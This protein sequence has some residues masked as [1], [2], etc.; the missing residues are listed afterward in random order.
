MNIKTNGSSLIS[1]IILS[2]I[3]LIILVSSLGLTDIVSNTTSAAQLSTDALFAA[4][5]TADD[6][7]IKLARNP[8]PTT[9]VAPGASITYANAVGY[10]YLTPPAPPLPGMVVAKGVS[11]K[12][13]RTI[14]VIYQ[15]R[16]D[17]RLTVLNR[18]E[19]SNTL[20]VLATP[21][22][23]STPA[24]IGAYIANAANVYL[25][26]NVNFFRPVGTPRVDANSFLSYGDGVVSPVLTLTPGVSDTNYVSG[27]VRK[28]GSGAFTFPVGDGGNYKPVVITTPLPAGNSYY[29]DV[30]YFRANPSIAVVSDLAGGF[31]APRPTGAPF[32]TSSLDTSN[33]LTA[34]TAVSPVEYWD[35]N[36]TNAINFTIAWTATSDVAT[37]TGSAL[38]KLTIVGWNGAKW[39]AVP[40]TVVS[41][42]TL[43]SGTIVTTNIPVP[44]TYM[45][46]TLGKLP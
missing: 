6:L 16:N 26:G 40:S 14:N 31:L 46:Y 36:G 11:G 2:S 7:L 5:S 20:D 28:Y 12:Y 1:V 45:V 30:A 42:S 37:L 22:P 41:G 29:M 35:I 33:P 32:S 18:Q 19:P 13:T 24:A 23:T 10:A 21:V 8:Y 4:E 27:Y 15:A 39:F 38:S 25:F 34:I 9:T 44:N 3:S 43:T 17:G